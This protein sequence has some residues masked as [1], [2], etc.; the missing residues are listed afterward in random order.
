MG[1]PLGLPFTL[2]EWRQVWN[3]ADHAIAIN[4]LQALFSVIPSKDGIQIF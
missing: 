3:P 1:R 4:L 2:T